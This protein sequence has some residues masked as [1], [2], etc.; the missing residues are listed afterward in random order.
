MTITRRAY[1]RKEATIDEF[2][3][4]F[5]TPALMNYVV[6]AIGSKRILDSPDDCFNDIPLSN[7]DRL[8]L[9]FYVDHAQWREA[10]EWE[11]PRTYPWSLSDNVC[12]AKTAAKLYKQQHTTSTPSHA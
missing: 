4:Q 9:Q 3:G 10:M 11:N 6:R 2:Y 5:I 7:W 1:M 12:I 8:A